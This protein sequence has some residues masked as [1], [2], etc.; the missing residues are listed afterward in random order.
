MAHSLPNRIVSG[1]HRFPEE[2]SSKYHAQCVSK[3]SISGQQRAQSANSTPSPV[4][5]DQF[6]KESTVVQDEIWKSSCSK[7]KHQQDK[8]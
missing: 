6:Q 2:T 3:P 1:P 7:E 4:S 5:Y 8:W